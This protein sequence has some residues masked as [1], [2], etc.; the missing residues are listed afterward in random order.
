[1]PSEK[2]LTE[3]VNELFNISLVNLIDRFNSQGW[4]YQGRTN[5]GCIE[6]GE[7]YEVFR[8]PYT[9]TKGDYE[10]WGIVCKNC[11][12]C[13]GLDIMDSLTKKHFRDYYSGCAY[14]YSQG[15]KGQGNFID[16]TPWS[17]KI[18]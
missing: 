18:N 2:T 17:K 7:D 11:E 10:Y 8:K 6:C 9:T 13:T 14:Y 1:M 5:I 3:L 16:L 4:R 12:T 15:Y